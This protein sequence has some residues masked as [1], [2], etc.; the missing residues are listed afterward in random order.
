MLL[1]EFIFVCIFDRLNFH[2]KVVYLTSKRT[3]YMSVDSH[4]SLEF[5]QDDAIKEYQSRLAFETNPAYALTA[6]KF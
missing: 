4:C 5:K 3:L 2:F 6:V 1:Y